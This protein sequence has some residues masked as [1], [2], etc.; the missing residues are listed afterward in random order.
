MENICENYKGHG[1][2]KA[3][4]CGGCTY[5][6]RAHRNWNSFI[7]D[8]DDVGQLRDKSRVTQS[9]P[10]SG[11]IQRVAWALAPEEIRDLQQHDEGLSV[12]IKCLEAGE[13]PDEKVLAMGSPAM[14]FY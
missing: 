3:L 5:C 2:L 8:I 7:A 12:I 1:D 4:P 10:V 6:S 13:I 11:E 9:F 14:K